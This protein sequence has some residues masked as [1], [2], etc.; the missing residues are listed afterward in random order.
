M[1]SVGRVDG[2]FGGRV[3]VSVKAREDKRQARGKRSLPPLLLP[4]KGS[5]VEPSAN[6]RFE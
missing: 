6:R 4:F 5:V 3:C 2:L 1:A